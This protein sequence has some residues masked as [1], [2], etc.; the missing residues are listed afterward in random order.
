MIKEIMNVVSNPELIIEFMSDH[1][2]KLVIAF[3]VFKVGKYF[4]K[5]ADKAL[6]I[7]FDKANTDKSLSSF[8]RSIIRILY[9]ILLILIVIGI[10]GI[11]ISTITTVLGAISIALGFAFKETLGNFFSGFIILAFKPFKVGDIIEYNNYQ[12]EVTSI[13]IFYTKIR[14]YQNESVIIPNSILT[15]NELRNLSRN[16]VRRLDLKITVD[17]DS[18]IRKVKE[19]LHE[20]VLSDQRVLQSPEYIIGLG[21]LGQIGLVFSVFVYVSV[22]N[23]RDVKYN[24]N[25]QIKI[26]FKENN[27]STPIPQLLGGQLK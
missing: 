9:F 18:D 1:A 14:N 25:E 21:E 4:S 7:L 2:L 6:K 10:L 26:R 15:S 17:Y 12:G 20:I 23:Y 24:L 27:I 11:N 13:E 22:E 5:Y 16:K 8:I 3:V 19:I